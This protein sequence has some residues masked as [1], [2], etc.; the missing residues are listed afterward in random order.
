[1]LNQ[2][3]RQTP[4]GH[5]A[6]VGAVNV[7]IIATAYTALVPEDSNPGFTELA[8]GG[9]G[10]N[11]GENLCRLGLPVEMVTM[12]GDDLYAQELQK[13]CKALGMGLEHSAFLEGKKTSTYICINDCTGDMKAAVSHMEIYEQLTPEFLSGRMDVLNTALAVV[14][15]TNIPKESLEY[16][17]QNCTAPLFL[18]PVSTKKAVRAKDCL[19]AMHTIKPN[20]IEAQLLSGVAIEGTNGLEQ[21]A[22][23]FINQGVKRVYIS[24]G[25]DGVFY[26]DE[27][28]TGIIPCYQYEVVSTTG[29]GD[30]FMAGAVWAYIHGLSTAQAATFA[31]G[32]SAVCAGYPGAVSPQ[33]SVEKILEK[34]NRS[35]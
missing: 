3:L 2:D 31:L 9:V 16:L 26:A 28:K 15:D 29:C 13:D 24:L 8:F 21:A 34:V 5:I 12:L 22:A 35:Q 7:D 23:F 33:M 14:L 19:S 30:A 20:R 1:M 10:R 4:T 6:V 25:Q 17:A 32:A 27:A 11:I 18:D